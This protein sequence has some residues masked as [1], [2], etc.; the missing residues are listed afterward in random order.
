MQAAARQG[1]PVL[2]VARS[3]GFEPGSRVNTRDEAQWRGCGCHGQR[4]EARAAGKDTS[5]RF[6]F[7]SSRQR[8]LQRRELVGL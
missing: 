7:S 5:E 8:L 6:C 2:L 1:R 4:A 3:R